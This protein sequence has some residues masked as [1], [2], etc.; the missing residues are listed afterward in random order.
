MSAWLPL[1]KP[2]ACRLCVELVEL[3]LI[4]CPSE[5]ECLNRIRFGRLLSK[6]FAELNIWHYSR[7]LR[8]ASCIL[9]A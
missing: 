2:V 5:L 7:E 9:N 8:R 6:L 4:I 1:Y 3:L